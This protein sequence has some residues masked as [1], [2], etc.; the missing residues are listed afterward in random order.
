[1]K[2]PPFDYVQAE[3]V[4]AAVAA[5][6]QAGGDAKI[7]A[8]GQ[9]LVPMLNFRLLR[10]SLLVDVNRIAALSFLED[11]GDSVH[12]GALVRHRELEVSPLIAKFFPV[13][14]EA[15]GHV[16]HLAI[17]NRGTIGGSLSHADPAAELPMLAVLL[18]AEFTIVSPRG[19][20]IVPAEAFFLGVLSTALAEDELLAAVRFPKLPAGSGWGF[21]EVARRHGDFALAAVAAT[22]SLRDG[23]VASARIAMMGVGDTPLR[24]SQAEALVV[25]EAVGPAL[26]AAVGD[27]AR[28]AAMPATDLHASADYRRHL[29]GV[30]A[31]RAVAAAWQRA[32]EADP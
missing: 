16:A 26:L 32:E 29:V 7:I 28:A 30:L 15:M 31:Q 2:P 14:V 17:R 9:S 8:G 1:M 23:T 3:S 19:A 18:G 12:I 24:A 6:A 13:V 22:V 20:R 25:G 5:L 10:P 21:V 27:A 4:E 11:N